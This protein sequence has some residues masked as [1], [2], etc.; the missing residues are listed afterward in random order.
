MA[1]MFDSFVINTDHMD[2]V[3]LNNKNGE[4]DE[5]CSLRQY[6]NYKGFNTTLLSAGSNT[7]EEDKNEDFKVSH[8]VS[9]KVKN[10]FIKNREYAD[11]KI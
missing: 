3:I 1:E 10:D 8:H 11:A 5:K 4:N 9:K 6:V 2:V 7:S